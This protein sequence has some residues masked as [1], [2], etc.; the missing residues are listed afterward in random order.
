MTEL[1]WRDKSVF[2]EKLEDITEVSIEYP[3]QKDQSFI[4]KK[5]GSKYEVDTFYP[6]TKKIDK[7]VHQGQVEA[8]LINF[9]YIAAESIVNEN[10]T[11]D[12]IRSLIPFSII[13][14]KKQD[15]EEKQVRLFPIA[16]YKTGI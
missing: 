16:T 7:P 2:H 4:L 10:S 13:K 12:S 1:E 14:L 15:G 3:L 6:T 5:K 8:F 11:K 9:E